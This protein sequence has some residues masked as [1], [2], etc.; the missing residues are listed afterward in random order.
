TYSYVDT[1]QLHFEAMPT[2]ISEDDLVNWLDKKTRRNGVTQVQLRAYLLKLIRY[3]IHDRKFTL[4]SLH[5]AQFQLVQA[6]NQ[7]IDRLFS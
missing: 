3:L 5:R 1:K 6:V 7:E 4:T 2:T